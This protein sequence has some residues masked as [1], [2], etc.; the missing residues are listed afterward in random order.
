MVPGIASENREKRSEGSKPT[1][2][3][4]QFGNRM[5]VLEHCNN[6]NTPL[7]VSL[8]LAYLQGK[9]IF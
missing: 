4:M 9:T 2:A 8:N 6:S 5:A 1:Q 3:K 7:Y